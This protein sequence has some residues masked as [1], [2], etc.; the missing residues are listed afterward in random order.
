MV[1]PDHPQGFETDVEP[2]QYEWRWTPTVDWRHPFSVNSRMM[3]LLGNADAAAIVRQR[4]P[5]LFYACQGYDNELQVMR[6]MEVANV[7]PLDRA[8]IQ[9]MDEPLRQVKI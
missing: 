1:L 2:G 7:M 4:V 5:M 8:A 3:D 9:A 6:P